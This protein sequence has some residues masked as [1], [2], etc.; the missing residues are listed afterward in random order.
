MYSAFA[1]TK[2]VTHV[3]R[4]P[5]VPTRQTVIACASVS[6]RDKK[7]KKRNGAGGR[8]GDT[9]SGHLQA[10]NRRDMRKIGQLWVREQ[11]I[12]C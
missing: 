3:R 11:Y 10:D 4:G 5:Q 9:A 1:L 2:S 12:L 7:K 6:G 8:G